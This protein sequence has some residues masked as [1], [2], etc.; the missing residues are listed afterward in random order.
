MIFG[1][2]FGVIII[3]GLYYI[4]AKIAEGRKLI[5]DEDLEP[6][7]E[8][9]KY[10]PPDDEIKDEDIGPLTETNDHGPTKNEIKD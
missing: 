5:K 3:P 6:Y 8:T 7:T 2:V 10:G 4:F 1:T 9:Y